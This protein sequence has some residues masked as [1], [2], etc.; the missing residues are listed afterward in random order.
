MPGEGS[1][2]RE[3]G[4]GRWSLT[5]AIGLSLATVGSVKTP[6]WGRRGG[7]EKTTGCGNYLARFHVLEVHA[8]LAG[9]AFPEPEVGCSDLAGGLRRAGG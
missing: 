8:D 3:S 6:T 1:V 2:S 5:T 7:T 9:D 4:A